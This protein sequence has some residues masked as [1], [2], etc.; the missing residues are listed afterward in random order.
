MNATHPIHARAAD[1]DLVIETLYRVAVD[2]VAW[3]QLIEVLAP[4]GLDA[5]APAASDLGRVQEIA[6][7]ARRPGE[8]PSAESRPDV[9][10]VVLSARGRVLTCNGLAAAMMAT[11]L[12]EAEVGRKIR[13]LDPGN[14]DT[15]ERALA[16]ARIGSEPVIVRLERPGQEGPCFA[17]AAPAS[18]LPAVLHEAAPTV[19]EPPVAAL[20]FPAAD[21]AS[22]LWSQVRESFGL[23]EAEVRLA[24]KL[25]EGR[26]LQDA[27]A[28]LGVAV[29]TVRNQ[30]RAIFDKMGLQR[31]SELVRALTELGAA[32][33]AMESASDPLAA[34]QG[35][36]PPVRQI[37][38]M[39]GRRLAY[40]EYG[41]PRG[42]ACLGFHEG[43]GSSLLPPGTQA[44]AE[45]LGLRIISPERPGF[46]QSDPRGDYSFDGVAEDMVAL[47]DRLG[48][49]EVVIAAVASGAPS[50]LQTA[51]RM[52]PRARFVVLCSGRPPRRTAGE[53]GQRNSHVLFRARLEANPWM[54]EAIY[55]ILR[56][57]R[58]H[59]LTRQM[60]RRTAAHSHGDWALL[61][62]HPATIDFVWRY[63]GEAL[64]RST[65][66]PVDEVRAFRQ[67]GNL[68]PAALS[69][70]VVVWHGEEDV[71]APLPDLLAYLGDKAREV[72][73]IEG[74]GHLMA[75]KHWDDILQRMAGE[76]P[77]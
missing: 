16:L 70:P 59:A 40:R 38:L 36:D 18:A 75:L 27:A 24:R 49:G 42:R 35:G 39:D 28:D 15:A 10:W 60:M 61:D 25:R 74:V 37:V 65:R 21:M 51:I 1:A 62:A 12:G 29:N 30:L 48:L 13:F 19:G 31:Q 17:Y 53:A 20:V 66:G 47:C 34:G 67:G 64:A 43:L 45:A 69:A 50:A 7:L 76:A 68:T 33:S 44:R 32:A 2:P 71:M 8:G 23:T 14:A 9:G 72:R 57:R 11:G 77:P 5:S 54:A 6:R 22:R 3:E 63:V 55:A 52:G 46:G 58:S 4:D 56:F 41:D 26:S 73:V